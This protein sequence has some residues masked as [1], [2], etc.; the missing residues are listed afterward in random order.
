MTILARAQNACVI[1]LIAGTAMLATAASAQ[2][3]GTA[4]EAKAMLAKTVAA[5]KAN[6]TMTLDQINNGEGGF[7]DRDLYPICFNLSDGKNI[8]VASPTAKQVLGMNVR[9]IKD[10][11]GKVF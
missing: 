11:T 5:L 10:P 2:Q 1:A 6:K 8:A 9:A 7:L 3:F 4:G